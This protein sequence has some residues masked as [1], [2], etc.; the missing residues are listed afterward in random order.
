MT[1]KYK[2]LYI[3]Y[4]I[5]S[6]ALVILP[7]LVYTIIGFCNGDIGKKISLGL[8]LILAIVMVLI[9]VII[10]HRVRSTI[11]IMIIGIYTCCDNIT[12]LLFILAAST[13]LDEFVFEPLAKKYK[14]KYV[15]N[16]E[17]DKRG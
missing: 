4:R 5:M 1:R 14:E 7:L 17:I 15:I 10:K 16:N 3:F 12:P 9:N 6:A 8:C 11:W 13:I 2:N